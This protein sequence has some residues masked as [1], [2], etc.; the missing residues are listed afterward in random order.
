MEAPLFFWAIKNVK[1]A[2]KKV[3]LTSTHGYGYDGCHRIVFQ[4]ILNEYDS[5][6]VRLTAPPTILYFFRGPP[7]SAVL[8]FDRL[9]NLAT[10]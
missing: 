6:Y 4:I 3:S 5:Y 2:P 10:I 8:E 1:M 7:S 9:R